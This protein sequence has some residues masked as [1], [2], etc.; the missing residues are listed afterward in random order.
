MMLTT[1]RLDSLRSVISTLENHRS[2]FSMTSES[3]RLLG[4]LLDALLAD[5]AEAE[6][7]LDALEDAEC[8]RLL[9]EI[10]ELLVVVHGGAKP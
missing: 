10:D 8:N 7:E 6:A 9:R 2:N 3:S 5:Q 1:P 4:L